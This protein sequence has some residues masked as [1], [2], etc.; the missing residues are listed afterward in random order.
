[1]P[2]ALIGASRLLLSAMLLLPVVLVLRPRL[3]RDAGGWIA[4]GISAALGF[5]ASFMLQGVGIARTTTSHAALVLTAAPVITALLQFLL[6]RTWPR[7]L[8]WLGSAIALLGEAVLIL[9]R[10]AAPQGA[11]ATILGDLTVLLGTITVSIGYLAGAGL[12]VRIGLFGATAW[13]ILF[14]ALLM[15]P[16]APAV[17]G[18]LPMLTPTGAI[19]LGFLAVFC[20]LVGFAAWF[21]ALQQ[22]GVESIAPL[23]FAQP[24]VALAIAAIWLSEQ[25]SGTV[26]VAMA[27]IL[28]G[29]YL[30]RK[31]R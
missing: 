24:V 4:L 7:P 17:I 12:S 16:V 26:V 21:W 27:L 10:G 23:Q 5:A 2:S 25:V 31:A 3:P 20:T 19:A 8:W 28:F 30:C 1:M 6:A 11:D 13:P 18:A 29:V 22:G 14:G 15:L 9:D